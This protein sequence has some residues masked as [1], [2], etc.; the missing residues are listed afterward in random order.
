MSSH[1]PAYASTATEAA[2]QV[3]DAGRADLAPLARELFDLALC[4]PAA[5]LAR[6]GDLDVE[7]LRILHPAHPSLDGR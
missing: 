1:A 4:N 3:T 6:R 2:Q 7:A 5:Y